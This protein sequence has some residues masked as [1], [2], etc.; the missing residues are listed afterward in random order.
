[1]LKAFLRLQSLHC[2]LHGP[3]D[4]VVEADLH[5]HFYKIRTCT[6]AIHFP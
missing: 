6:P 5:R 1:M 4:G 2:R 3:N